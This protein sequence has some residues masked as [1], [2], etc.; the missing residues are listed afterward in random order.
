MTRERPFVIGLTGSIGMGKSTTAAMFSEFGVPVWDA[1]AAVARLYGKGGAAVKPIA[2]LRREAI[3][4]GAV[5]RA[6]L[7]SWI[8]EDTTALQQIEAVVH[9]LVSEDRRRF[10]EGATAP[11]VL[12]DI[13]LLYETNAAQSVDAVVVV[14]APEDLQ[15]QRVLDR[16]GMTP[17]H[18]ARILGK[19]TPD[20]E[21]RARADYVIETVTLEA[22]RAAVQSCLND[23]KSRLSDA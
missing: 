2:R 7:K 11:I 9:P 23:I 18:L 16:P 21:K 4:D 22:A 10:L 17:D 14:S 8:A 19:Q 20:A 3:K 15:R 6:A 13:P 1:D 5:D 12:L